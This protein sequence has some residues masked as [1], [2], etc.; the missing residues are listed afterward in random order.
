ME[1]CWP[2]ELVVLN[3]AWELGVQ[4]SMNV[5]A[6]E[7]KSEACEN[8]CTIDSNYTRLRQPTH[9]RRGGKMVENPA[10]SSWRRVNW[11]TS[12][13][14]QRGLVECRRSEDSPVCLRIDLQ[15]YYYKQILVVV[16]VWTLRARDET[17]TTCW[18][19]ASRFRHHLWQAKEI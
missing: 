18:Q 11:C 13:K 16:V 17:T 5:N 12:K 10:G 7:G 2:S 4:T 8:E 14:V 15:Y 9:S 19:S 3:G 6:L 1:G